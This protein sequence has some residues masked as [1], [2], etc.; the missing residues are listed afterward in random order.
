M[1]VLCNDVMCIDYYDKKN[2]TYNATQL[3]LI[4]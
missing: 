1:D 2:S 3:V 4:V